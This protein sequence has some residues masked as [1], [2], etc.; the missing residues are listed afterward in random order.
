M[1]AQHVTVSSTGFFNVATVGNMIA[2]RFTEIGRT[3]MPCWDMRTTAALGLF[4]GV[5]LPLAAAAQTP[6]PA[7]HNACFTA[8]E[9]QN[10]KAPDDRTIFIRVGLHR[11]FRLDLAGTCAPLRWPDSHLITRLRGTDTYC[12]AVDWDLKVSESPHGIPETC[13]V[14]KMTELSPEEAAAIPPKFR[15]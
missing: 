13:I 14:K 6:P 7:P 3:T 8:N 1:V 15:P 11:F 12:S 2:T 9:F 5:A 4:A 10:W